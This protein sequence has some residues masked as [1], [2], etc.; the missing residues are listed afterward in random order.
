[1]HDPSRLPHAESLASAQ[2][3]FTM[4]II[5]LA[6]LQARLGESFAQALDSLLVCDGRVVVTA[7]DS[8]AISGAS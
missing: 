6:A 8:P 3:T 7:S 2:R 1:M 5:A 4:A